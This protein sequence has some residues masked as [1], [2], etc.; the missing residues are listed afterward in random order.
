MPEIDG[1]KLAKLIKAVENVWFKELKKTGDI[2]NPK[3][4]RHCPI[5]AVT[6]VG[7]E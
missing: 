4:E 7:S 5:V 6:A 2:R 1:F 3:A